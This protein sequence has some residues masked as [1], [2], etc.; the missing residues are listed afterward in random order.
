MECPLQKAWLPDP[1]ETRIHSVNYPLRSEIWL[2]V[3]A[4]FPKSDTDS[5]RFAIMADIMQ[6]HEP[7]S[8][9]LITSP[10]ITFTI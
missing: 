6:R 1:P 3:N 5:W 2:G 9:L 8:A 7:R 4:R 10:L